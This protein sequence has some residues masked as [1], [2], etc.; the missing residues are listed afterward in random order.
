VAAFYP[1]TDLKRLYKMKWPW[2]SPNVVGL[3]AT[4][5]FLG[6]TPDTVPDRYRISSPIAHVDADDPPTF[7]VHGG[8]DRLVPPE[9]SKLFAERLQEADVP[10]RLVELPWANHSFDHAFGFSWSGWGSQIARS[11]FA[12]FLYDH[13]AAQSG[14]NGLC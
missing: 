14:P 13:L 3:D 8:A 12:E 10:H 4:R 5:R 7:L 2:S 1:P 11:T 9:Q 6:G